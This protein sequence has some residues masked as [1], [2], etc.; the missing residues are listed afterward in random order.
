MKG[1]CIAFIFNKFITKF[2][3][4]AS[5]DSLISLTAK[6][7]D[8]LIQAIEVPFVIKVKLLLAMQWLKQEISNGYKSY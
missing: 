6:T 4:K 3:W 2:S 8:V 1:L 5:N 7:Q